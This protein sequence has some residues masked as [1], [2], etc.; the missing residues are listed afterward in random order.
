[1]NSN[2]RLLLDFAP[3]L[4]FFAVNKWLGLAPA[5]AV[6]IAATLVALVVVYALERKI[7]LM[8]LISGVAVSVMGGLTLVLHDETYI[9]IKPTVVNGI[10]GAVLLGG[11]Y[12]RKATFKYVLGHAMSLEDE[13][14]RLLSLRW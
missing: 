7:A 1:M 11:V 9:K 4:S 3:L 8:A 10:F 14:W 5:T 12:F 13:G 6:L 2:L